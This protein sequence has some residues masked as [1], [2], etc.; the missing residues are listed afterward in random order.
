[1]LYQS[2]G[3]SALKSDSVCFSIQNHWAHMHA[4]NLSV[5]AHEHTVLQP[6]LYK[7]WLLVVESFLIEVL[8]IE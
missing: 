1:M 8:G 3:I 5:I 7:R 4:T 2:R 6:V